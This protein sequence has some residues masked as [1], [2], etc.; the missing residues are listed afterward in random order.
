MIVVPSTH[1]TVDGLILT[2]TGRDLWLFRS[3]GFID[4]FCTGFR[5]V[6]STLLSVG[7]L[8][9]SGSTGVSWFWIDE[10][11]RLMLFLLTFAAGR[12]GV[13]S[14]NIVERLCCW[15]GFRL[16]FLEKVAS[17]D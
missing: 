9:V 1:D 14:E 15:R 10:S 12:I 17:S 5:R 13:V 8:V 4:L 16:S 11:S 7:L 6:T 3:M 2:E